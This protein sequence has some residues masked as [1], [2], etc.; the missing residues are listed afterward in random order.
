VDFVKDPGGDPPVD[1]NAREAVARHCRNV[2]RLAR[3]SR[4]RLASVAASH[5]FHFG[6]IERVLD[7]EDLNLRYD[8]LAF[9]S[10]VLEIDAIHIFEG[11]HW[12][13]PTARQKGIFIVIPDGAEDG[14][15]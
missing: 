2:R 7:G 3:D 9:P 11:V 5:G 14:S 6:D 1:E 12:V 13:P 10:D 8:E 15:R 4:A